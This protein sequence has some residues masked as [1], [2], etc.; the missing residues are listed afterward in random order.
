[1]TTGL[2]DNITENLLWGQKLIIKGSYSVSE[3]VPACYFFKT[4]FTL[5]M[6]LNWCFYGTFQTKNTYVL[7]YIIMIQMRVLH[8]LLICTVLSEWLFV[9]FLLLFVNS[10]W[11]QAFIPSGES[12]S[13][14]DWF[15]GTKQ[16]LVQSSAS[17]QGSVSAVT[18]SVQKTTNW[19]ATKKIFLN[20]R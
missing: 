20:P 2:A 15:T 5:G 19:W 8:I 18:S 9:F 11:W 14:T 7:L 16:Q 4:L 1:M 10:R 3:I 13:S 17:P 12:R 6:F